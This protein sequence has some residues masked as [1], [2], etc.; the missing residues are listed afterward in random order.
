[1]FQLLRSGVGGPRGPTAVRGQQQWQVA[2]RNIATQTGIAT[3]TQS[4]VRPSSPAPRKWW[5]VDAD[6]MIPGRLAATISVLL[7]GKHKPSFTPSQD[8]GD[9][10]VV[11]NAGNVL[12]TGQKWKQK[13][14]RHHTGWPGG[15]KEVPAKQLLEQ[16]PERIMQRAVRGMLPKNKLRPIRMHRLRVFPGNEHPHTAQTGGAM[17]PTHISF[18]PSRWKNTWADPNVHRVW[19]VK[20]DLESNP[21]VVTEV[22]TKGTKRVRRREP[23]KHPW[24]TAKKPTFTRT[25]KAKTSEMILDLHA[26][27]EEDYY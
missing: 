23:A 19:Q 21:P 2:Q 3:G 10:V 24:L 17:V 6:G 18:E 7:Q 9:F 12:F 11:I 5:V 1:M 27:P 8:I 14:Y 22:P 13:L 16:H 26:L 4:H 20:L 15:L 25:E